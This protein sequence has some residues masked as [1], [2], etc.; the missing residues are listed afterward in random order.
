MA[1]TRTQKLLRVGKASK[2]RLES[3]SEGVSLVDD[4]GMSIESLRQKAACE[5]WKLALEHRREGRKLLLMASPPYRAIV[6]RCYYVMYHAMRAACYLYHKGDDYESHSKLPS[7]LP[8]DFPGNADW[9]HTLKRARLDRNAAD[10]DP[11]PKSQAFWKGRAE[12]MLVDAKLL[13]KEVRK[14]LQS[15]GCPGV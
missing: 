4:F 2:E 13:V 5:R 1:H 8:D 12:G 15:K 10:Y 14:Y 7:H 9:T 11:Y 3:W 6:S